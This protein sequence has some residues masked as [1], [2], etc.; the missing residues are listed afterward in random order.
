M[1]KNIILVIS[2]SLLIYITFFLFCVSFRNLFI[3]TLVLYTVR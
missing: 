3:L 2:I 1:I